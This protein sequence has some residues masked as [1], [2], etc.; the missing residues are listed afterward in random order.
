MGAGVR[1]AWAHTFGQHGRIRPDNMGAGVQPQLPL[2]QPLSTGRGACATRHERAGGEKE[3][4]SPS[5]SFRAKRSGVEESQAERHESACGGESPSPVERD[6][7]RGRRGV[8]MSRLH[9]FL[10]SLDMTEGTRGERGFGAASPPQTPPPA[11]ATRR[12]S[13]RSGAQSRNLK[14][15][16]KMS[17]QARHDEKVELD[18]TRN[19][20]FEI[21]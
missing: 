9:S 7:G 17:R 2:P 5:P 12:H 21:L 16:V 14:P 18:M 4:P 11:T 15:R 6:L 13:E 1:T 10:V 19:L 3:S 20:E 8:E